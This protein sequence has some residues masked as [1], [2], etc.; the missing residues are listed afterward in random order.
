VERDLH[1]RIR[2]LL[3]SVGRPAGCADCGLMVYLL[4]RRAAFSGV[5]AYTEEG[6]LHVH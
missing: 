4:Y 2:D 5:A 3:Q 1:K 6:V